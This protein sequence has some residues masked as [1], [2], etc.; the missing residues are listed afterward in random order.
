MWEKELPENQTTQWSD[1]K[2]EFSVHFYR[3]EMIMSQN[4]LNKASRSWVWWFTP[5]FPALRSGDRRI[6]NLRPT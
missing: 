5:V 3:T 6:S 1:I 2:Y 4:C